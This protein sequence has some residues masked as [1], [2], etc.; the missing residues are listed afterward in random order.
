ML[1]GSRSG[2]PGTCLHDNDDVLLMVSIVLGHNLEMSVSR[3]VMS[4]TYCNDI[5]WWMM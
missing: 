5:V 4:I 1:N 2:G 3:L